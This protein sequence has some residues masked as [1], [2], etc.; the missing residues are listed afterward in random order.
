MNGMISVWICG[1][2]YSA[3]CVVFGISGLIS[4]SSANERSRSIGQVAQGV[5]LTFVVGGAYYRDSTPIASGGV[6]V[7]GLLIIHALLGQSIQTEVVVP[8]QDESA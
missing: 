3:W 8:R 7:L 6:V 5:L 4:A 2:L 1:L